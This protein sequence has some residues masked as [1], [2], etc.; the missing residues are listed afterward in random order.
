MRF[1]HV[2]VCHLV[3]F[4]G[5][6][7]NKEVQLVELAVL[8]SVCHCDHSGLRGRGRRGDRGVHGYYSCGVFDLPAVDAGLDR[9]LPV[10][11]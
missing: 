6:E 2:E 4:L 5:V 3:H 7:R 11:R 8:R 10:E 9:L 1:V